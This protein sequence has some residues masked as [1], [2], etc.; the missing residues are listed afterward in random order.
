MSD[1]R[2]T[3]AATVPLTSRSIVERAE[4]TRVEYPRE[5]SFAARILVWATTGLASWALVAFVVAGI[6][7]L[8]T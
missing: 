4:K 7:W 5:V 6:W 2:R 1:A 8:V 3:I